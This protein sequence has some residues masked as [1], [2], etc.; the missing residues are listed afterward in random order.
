MFFF[1]SGVTALP[2]FKPTFPKWRGQPLGAIVKNID[3][4]GLDLLQVDFL[5]L[6]Y[7]LSRKE[8]T[9]VHSWS[10]SPFYNLHLCLSRCLPPSLLLYLLL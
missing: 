1:C 5:F 4:V 2:D 3:A 7:T 8:L 10:V 6:I 9:H